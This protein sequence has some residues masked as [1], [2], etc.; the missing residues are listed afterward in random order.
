MNF[1][2]FVA[3]EKEMLD[4][5]LV[6]WQKKHEEDQEMFPKELPEGE[7]SEQFVLFCEQEG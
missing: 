7:W 3:K 4:K 1:R 6:F 2:K 5:F